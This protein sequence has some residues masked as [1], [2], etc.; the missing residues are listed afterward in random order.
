LSSVMCLFSE[1]KK[2]AIRPNKWGMTAAPA[3]GL[4][5]HCRAPAP[6]VTSYLI[7]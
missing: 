6:V 1:T 5:R 4:R 7:R 3:S 2:A